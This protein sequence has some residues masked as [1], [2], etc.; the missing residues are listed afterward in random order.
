VSILD[1]GAKSSLDPPS[2]S[3]SGFHGYDATAS[4]QGASGEATEAPDGEVMITE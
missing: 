2:L 3:I 4:R 1:R